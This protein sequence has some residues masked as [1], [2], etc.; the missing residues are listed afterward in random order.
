MGNSKSKSFKSIN[1]SIILGLVFGLFSISPAYAD[2]ISVTVSP[3]NPFVDFPVSSSGSTYRVDVSYPAGG[4]QDPFVQL[5]SGAAPVTFNT[6]TD[7]NPANP[8][9]EDDDGGPGRSSLIQGTVLSGDYTIRVSSWWYWIKSPS[10]TETYTLSYTGFTSGFAPAA[11]SNYIAPVPEPYFLSLTPPQI[12]AKDK[13][14]TCTSGTYQ[15]GYA[16]RG[17][18]PTNG[19]DTYK[20]SNYVY[21]LFING[22]PQNSLA[23][24]TSNTSAT[25]DLS[26]INVTGTATC[27]VSAALNSLTSTDSSTG[28]IEGLQNANVLWQAQIAQAKAE[29]QRAFFT[30]S[31]SYQKAL[32]DNR[33]KWRA[34]I[35]SIRAAYTTYLGGAQDLNGEKSIQ[36]KPLAALQNMIVAQKRSALDFHAGKP[37]ALSAKDAAN[38]AALDAKSTAIAKADSIYGTF[39][40]SIGYGV[41][42]P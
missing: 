42:I 37:A 23:V 7:T 15:A 2:D 25:W 36:V 39:I 4:A 12:H 9:N 24:S 21:T 11:V 28:N 34:E 41:L 32:V 1:F 27:S 33:A 22:Q 14:L 16:L 8:F 19:K 29:E 30:N 20:P 6:N 18:I 17:E 35:E 5:Y 3:A 31:N 13:Q 38:T 10:P 26:S 40:E